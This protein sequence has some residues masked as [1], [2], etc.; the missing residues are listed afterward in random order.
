MPSG[1]ILIFES[2]L[3]SSSPDAIL[4]LEIATFGRKRVEFNTKGVL[5]V[6]QLFS[7]VTCITPE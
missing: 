2:N 7:D 6:S 3:L 4:I 5:L 1:L